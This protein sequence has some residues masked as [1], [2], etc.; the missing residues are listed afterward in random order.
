MSNMIEIGKTYTHY[1]DGNKYTVL[2]IAKHSETCEQMVVYQ[3]EYGIRDIWVRPA[4]MWN[5]IIS[6]ENRTEYGQSVRFKLVDEDEEEDA[7]W[8]TDTIEAYKD[9][10]LI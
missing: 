8:L 1:K 5:E 7:E 10:K 4:F 6:I 3:A 2:R 9:M